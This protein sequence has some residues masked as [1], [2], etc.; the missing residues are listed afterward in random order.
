MK[1]KPTK[2][3]L[4]SGA[5]TGWGGVTAADGAPGQKLKKRKR[6]HGEQLLGMAGTVPSGADSATDLGSDIEY[7][8]L[9]DQIYHQSCGGV[10]FRYK[11]TASDASEG[12]APA[13]VDG[14]ERLVI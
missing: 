1:V 5:K 11:L 6:S 10:C 9:E 8:K 4:A 2:G 13:A 7:R 3:H 14:R 12:G